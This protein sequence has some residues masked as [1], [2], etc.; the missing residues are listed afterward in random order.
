MKMAP[1]H[2]LISLTCS[3]YT[4]TICIFIFPECFTTICVIAKLYLRFETKYSVLNMV[5]I[6]IYCEDFGDQRHFYPILFPQYVFLT[7]FA[8]NG[9]NRVTMFVKLMK[10]YRASL[11]VFRPVDLCLFEICQSFGISCQQIYSML[12]Y[13]VFLLNGC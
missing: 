6:R 11:M 12:I 4:C 9:E 3:G 13:F 2:L 5:Y 8:E 10:N 7:D 1:V